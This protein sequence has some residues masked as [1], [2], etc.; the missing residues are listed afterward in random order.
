MATQCW[1]EGSLLGTYCPGVARKSPYSV[2][3]AKVRKASRPSGASSPSLGEARG[4]SIGGR[5]LGFLPLPRL[6]LV[7]LALAGALVAMVADGLGLVPAEAVT[8]YMGLT[9]PKGLA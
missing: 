6:G 3:S 9:V 8:P 4:P 1:G 7:S 2:A 5:A